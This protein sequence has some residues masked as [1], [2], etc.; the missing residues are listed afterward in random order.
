MHILG[1]LPTSFSDWD[2]KLASIMFLGGCNLRCPFCQN[3]PLLNVAEHG[4]PIPWKDV[5]RHLRDKKLWIDGIVISGGEPM[6]HPEL[7][8]LCRTI[9]EAGFAVK[10]DTNGSFPYALMKLC[11]ESLVDYVA[12]DIKTAMDERYARA[13]GEK[14][15]VGLVRRTA[16]FLLEGK[17]DYEFRTTLVPG[18]VGLDEVKSIAADVKGARKYALQQ[19]VPENARSVALRRKKPYRREAVMKMA[20]VLKP[21]VGEVVLRGKLDAVTES[22]PGIQ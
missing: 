13:C 7:V 6:M 1:F 3:Y 4:S 17:T 15:E 9:K 8:S 11:K 2:G 21:A 10:L 18:M 5:A 22:L 19:F 14:V 16:R 12:M 20:E